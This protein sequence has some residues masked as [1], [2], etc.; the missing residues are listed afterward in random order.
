VCS[1]R[2]IS[3]QSDLLGCVS[4]FRKCDE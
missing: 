3:F 2:T 4:A 1:D